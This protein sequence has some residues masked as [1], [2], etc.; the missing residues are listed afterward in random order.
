MV[1]IGARN[2]AQVVG[3]QVATVVYDRNVFRCT[4]RSPHYIGRRGSRV[5]VALFSND[6]N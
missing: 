5:V 1:L 6:R 4:A 2:V 3:I